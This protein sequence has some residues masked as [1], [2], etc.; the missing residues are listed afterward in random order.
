MYTY[1]ICF[2]IDYHYY[3]NPLGFFNLKTAS[4]KSNGISMIN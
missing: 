2:A 4:N 3:Y 1:S